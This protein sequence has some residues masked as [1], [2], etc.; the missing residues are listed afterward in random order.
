MTSL[1]SRRQRKSMLATCTVSSFI[2][3]CLGL[4]R[5]PG[6]YTLSQRRVF[7]LR[8]PGAVKS[9]QSLLRWKDLSSS[10]EWPVTTGGLCQGLLKLLPRYMH[11]P[12]REYRFS[13]QGL[14]RS[15]PPVEGSAGI[16][17]C[18]NFDKGFVMHT[19]ASIRG[20]GAV[21]EQEQEDGKLCPVAYTSRSLSKA[22]WNYG[23]EVLGVVWE[24][25]TIA[26]TC[27]DTSAQWIL[28]T[29]LWSL[30]WKPSTLQ[31]FGTMESV[32]VWSW[33]ALQAW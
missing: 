12:E 23:M 18:V 16:P 10:L 3:K 33:V 8:N 7:H 21:L 1:Y 32:P 6:T 5:I 31:E 11:W 28:T 26:H 29:P 25:N 4:C 14:P 9:F 22:E 19:D 27:T 15:V 20:L 17:T 24:P 2:Q 30:C 13:G